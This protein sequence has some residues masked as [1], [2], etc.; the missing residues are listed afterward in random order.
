MSLAQISAGRRG[1][2]WG[3]D[4][5]GSPYRLAGS[6][7][8]PGAA[9]PEPLASLSVADA[10]TLLAAGKSGKLYFF[11][12]GAWVSVPGPG[13]ITQ[14]AAGNATSLWA[15]QDDGRIVTLQLS[16]LIDPPPR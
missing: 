6:T 4:K 9:A 12:S 1:T 5:D 11:V 3:L 7:W 13:N 10:C 15:L 8:Q 14:V 2:I 16:A